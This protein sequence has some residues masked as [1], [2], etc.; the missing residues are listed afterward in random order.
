MLYTFEEGDGDTIGDVSGVGEP[1]DLTIAD[2]G[3]VSWESGALVLQDGT[4]ATSS[5]PATKIIDACKDSNELTLEAWLVA[6]SARPGPT[7][8]VVTVSQDSDFRNFMLAQT[9][10]AWDVRVRMADTNEA[11]SPGTSSP[12][13]ATR[14][15][16]VVYTLDGDGQVMI[17][18][19]G[20]GRG[21]VPRGGDL[22]GWDDQYGLALG[23]EMTEDAP[24]A[25]SLH[26]VAVYCAALT[27]DEVEGN[28]RSGP[29]PDGS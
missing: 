4:I 15:V 14:V 26:L 25:G 1:L 7:T 5:G 27:P 3:A 16:H 22:S 6:E 18:A 20:V 19:D 10:V 9:G 17:Y 2:V 23:N 21:P 29:D 8:P 28:F 12:S 11:G 24:W 13:V